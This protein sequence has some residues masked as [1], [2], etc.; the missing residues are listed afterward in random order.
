MSARI[1]IED[2]IDGT[3]CTCSNCEWRGPWEHGTEITDAILTP[4]DPS[5]CV[6]CPECDSLAYADKPS[7]SINAATRAHI[8]E[9]CDYIRK[10]YADGKCG[11]DAGMIDRIIELADLHETISTLTL[12]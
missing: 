2:P 8:R 9:L 7:D 10:G 4:G 11:M 3:T 5:P 12:E 6:R 1:Y